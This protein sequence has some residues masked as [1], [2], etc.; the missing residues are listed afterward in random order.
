MRTHVSAYRAVSVTTVSYATP[1]PSPPRHRRHPTPGSGSLFGA[2][3][4]SCGALAGYTTAY[5]NLTA[6]SSS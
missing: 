6:D 5:V 2:F 3:P 4:Q 1:T